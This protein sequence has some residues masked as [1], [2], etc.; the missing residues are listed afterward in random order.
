MRCRTRSAGEVPSNPWR[1]QSSALFSRLDAF[2]ERCHDVLDLSQTAQ[3]FHR[4]E[5][6]EIGGTK[7]PGYI[8]HCTSAGWGS[9][10]HMECD[11]L[12]VGRPL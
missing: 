7:V 12:L 9:M 2:L 1:F 4:L 8:T 11:W 3:Q 10:C 5:R 6:V